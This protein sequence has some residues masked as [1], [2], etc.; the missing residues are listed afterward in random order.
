[1]TVSLKTR[2]QPLRLIIGVLVATL[3]L[4]NFTST[5]A[6]AITLTTISGHITSGGQHVVGMSV[7][8]SSCS[9]G[10]VTGGASTT[11][12]ETGYFTF[13]VPSGCTGN[14]SLGSFANNSSSMPP[15]LQV[16]GS[17]TAP[18]TS[19][20][21]DVDIPT[22]VDLAV[23]PTYTDGT[24]IS[25]GAVYF[26][27]NN[28]W[29]SQEISFGG[30]T[31]S[32]GWYASVYT[33]CSFS[34]PTTCHFAVPKNSQSSLASYA[35]FGG[36]VT[37][38]RYDTVSAGS[39]DTST[40]VTFNYLPLDLTTISGHITMN[41]VG[42]SGAHVAVNQCRINGLEGGGSTT[43]SVDG[44][45]SL[46]LPSNCAGTLSFTSPYLASSADLPLLQMNGAY[47]VPASNTTV[48][49]AVPTPVTLSVPT[50]F[51][52]GTPI[53]RGQVYF[54]DSTTWPSGTFTFGGQNVSGVWTRSPYLD[55]SFTVAT[56]CSFTVPQNS[57]SIVRA[58]ANFG[59]G[60]S[61]Y[62]T[63]TVSVGTVD[64][65]S[66]I[67]FDLLPFDTVTISGHISQSGSPLPGVTVG[68]DNCSV[69][70]I[71]GQ[72]NST[73]DVAGTYSIELPASCTGTLH[74]STPDSYSASALPVLQ[75]SGPYTVADTNTV[76][77]YTVP[78]PVDIAVTSQFT[79]GSP[80]P[81]GAVYITGDS[82][83]LRD[84]FT[85]GGTSLPGA[86]VR[87]AY[88]E[89]QFSVAT[90]CHLAVPPH[91]T[92]TLAAYALLGGGVST[93]KRDTRTIGT[94]DTS[95]TFTFNN[96][97]EL[98]SLG[99][100]NG[101]VIIF[102]DT[103][104]AITSPSVATSAGDAIPSGSIDL[105]GTLSYT[106]TGLTVGQTTQVKFQIPAGNSLS[107]AVKMINGVLVDLSPIASISGQELTLTLTDGGLGDDD[108]IANGSIRDP[109]V[110]VH[111]TK[112]AQAPLAVQT[113]GN[114]YIGQN[115]A[116]STTG[117]SGSGVV[118]YA[119]KNGTASGCT[120]VGA[121]VRASSV[122]T[123]I[124][125]ASKAGDSIYD[126]KSSAFTSILF[127]EVPAPPAPGP[128]PPAPTPTPT[129]SASPTPSVTPTPSPTA[130]PTPS[131]TPSVTPSATATPEP[132]LIAPAP[133]PKGSS[134]T[135]IPSNSYVA[136]S[137]TTVRLSKI[138]LGSTISKVL[139]AV[140]ESVQFSIPAAKSSLTTKALLTLPDGKRLTIFN[141]T[142]LAK[143]STLLP[144]LTFKRAGSFLLTISSGSSTKKFTIS[145]K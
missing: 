83:W 99:S 40:A 138:V 48:D 11:T 123:C 72:G 16:H 55:C 38:Y 110:V 86:W 47:T 118:S 60:V 98:G 46:E 44:F 141:G 79:N 41:S 6:S 21:V 28:S 134:S 43:T 73:T 78:A 107:S 2:K 31:L 84:N 94:I 24:P 101:S 51:S 140:K 91:S 7:A 68:V 76:I 62:N 112:S 89:C 97:A 142:S 120:V 137:S 136:K 42:L 57:T 19:A 122:G 133:K 61:S 8:L 3:A 49:F 50:H 59:G 69:G 65:S 88:E 104:T 117:G 145:V 53:S 124:V 18:L 135:T 54:V 108:G 80:I 82:V 67:S 111:N 71:T 39:V 5:P 15:I 36:G 25:H 85:F 29:P 87:S 66:A 27:S 17:Y 119:G 96:L 26:N 106:I 37:T 103:A 70:G 63:E 128:V 75:L 131:P 45:Y 35:I 32:G 127:T 64:T 22:T 58:F 20:T 92:S 144:A 30:A 23:S 102:T 12:D 114:F 74:L 52:D 81:H 34:A 125:V 4:A 9:I 116:L 13:D 115:N 56:T 143:K 130:T 139:L 1:M 10:D 113:S 132:V 109:L 95:T 100:N 77:D 121:Q 129:P 105:T 14:L 93:Y 33:S 126:L 90:T